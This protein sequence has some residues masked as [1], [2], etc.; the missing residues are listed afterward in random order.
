MTLDTLR[1][2][3]NIL[4]RTF[5]VGY[6]LAIFIALV[7]FG[8]WDAWIGF[9]MKLAHTDQAT[10]AAVVLN[11]FAGIKFFL[12]FV[13]LTPAL[14][15]HW[16]IKKELCSRERASKIQNESASTS[17]PRSVNSENIAAQH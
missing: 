4:L 16:T 14:A 2:T 11:F 3:R 17:A 13:V 12:L 15:I 6:V 10:L 5:V 9:S 8:A 7:T 1:L